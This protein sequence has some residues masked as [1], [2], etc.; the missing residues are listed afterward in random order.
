MVM[1]KKL[2]SQL[3]K[4]LPPASAEEQEGAPAHSEEELASLNS[5][6]SGGALFA[7]AISPSPAKKT[8]DYSHGFESI[9]SI[10]TVDVKSIRKMGSALPKEEP[11]K[12]APAKAQIPLQEAQLDLLL[13]AARKEEMESFRLH[14]P[15]QVLRLP[16]QAQ[17]K[18]LESGKR[19]LRDLWDHET[20]DMIALKGMGQGHLDEIRQK[21]KDYFSAGDPRLMRAVDFES[22]IRC[23]VGEMEPQRAWLFLEKYELDHLATLTSAE[24]VAI[25][26]LN[27]TQKAEVQAAVEQ[28]L[29][30]PEKRQFIESQLGLVAHS[31][32]IPW[33]RHRF[34]AAAQVE[35]EDR[36]EVIA[37]N[38]KH[39]PAILRLFSQLYF[40]GGFLLKSG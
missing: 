39:L 1:I 21:L 2:K 14:E 31:Y 26:H 25:R 19:T 16:Q 23:L 28:S 3:E 24:S 32:L 18:L 38:P 27:A 35:L 4:M 29:L 8:P 36:L 7:K 20:G 5:T 17:Q 6:L 37:E 30:N 15:L 10:E 13:D 9:Y 34:G 22:L 12:S 33:M 11:K 40:D